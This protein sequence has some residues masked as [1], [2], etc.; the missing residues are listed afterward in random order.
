MRLPK[1]NNVVL[2]Q[3]VAE[4]TLGYFQAV[5]GIGLRAAVRQL[6]LRLVDKGLQIHRLAML[7]LD[8][9]SVSKLP[10]GSQPLF[11][12]SRRLTFTVARVLVR[13]PSNGPAVKPNDTE[14]AS[15]GSVL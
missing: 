10:F 9:A 14:Y 13:E 15:L 5:R 2:L 7:S 6:S 3:P 8:G 12:R 11:T 1:R 4:L